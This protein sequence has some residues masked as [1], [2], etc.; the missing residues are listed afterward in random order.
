MKLGHLGLNE[1]KLVSLCKTSQGLYN[2]T[3]YHHSP[4]QLFIKLRLLYSVIAAV[5]L[6]E[7]LARVVISETRWGNN[8]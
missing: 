7:P 4:E 2:V 3:V 1:V 5:V 6:M 8:E